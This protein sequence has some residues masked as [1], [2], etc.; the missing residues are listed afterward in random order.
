MR[1]RRVLSLQAFSADEGT[2]PEVR[3]RPD[4]AAL[5]ARV[6]A[7]Q[8]EVDALR[9]RAAQRERRGL[10]SQTE[11]RNALQGELRAAPDAKSVV[12][13]LGIHNFREIVDTHG[14]EAAEHLCL[15]VGRW[16]IAHIR[17]TDFVGR[18]GAGSFALFLGFADPPGAQRKLTKLTGKIAATPCRWRDVQLSASLDFA[19]HQIGHITDETRATRVQS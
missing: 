3:T 12:A 17:H 15:H 18:V 5:E 2:S 11:F 8:T 19:I 9:R 1:D 4:V 14:D 16:L 7:L 10:L 6:A 13:R